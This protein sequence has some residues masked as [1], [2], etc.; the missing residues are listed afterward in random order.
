M[1][2]VVV[3][4]D[5]E[6]AQHISASFFEETGF[7]YVI[8]VIDGTHLEITRPVGMIFMFFRSSCFMLL[9]TAFGA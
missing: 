7:P 3:W 6:E 1:L 5:A 9:L 4:P 8:G 2:Q